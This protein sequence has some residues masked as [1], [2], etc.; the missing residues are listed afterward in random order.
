LERD[1]VLRVSA[2]IFGG[3]PPVKDIGLVESAVF[4]P[5]TTVFGEDAYPTLWLKAAALLH[6]LARNH[7]FHDG[8]KRTA[9]ASTWLFL[10]KNGW[11]LVAG[12]DVDTAEV[13]MNA[14]AVGD[15][16]DDLLGVAK[17]LEALAEPM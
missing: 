17:V 13:F 6:S 4:R 10:G 1:D 2:W 3:S 9:W 12:F 8:N 16:D 14:V 15:Y 7:G 5:R 11:L